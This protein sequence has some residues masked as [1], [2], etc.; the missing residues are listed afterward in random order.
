MSNYPLSFYAKL[1]RLHLR[2]NGLRWT[3]LFSI[4]HFI[5]E[6]LRLVEK[7]SASLERRFSLPGSNSIEENALKWNNYRWERGENEWTSSA[8]WKQSVIDTIIL[9]NIPSDSVVLEIG[10]GFGR[11]TRKLIEISSRVMVVDV[12]KKCID[13]CRSVFGDNDNVEFHVNDGRSLAFAD[14]NSVDFIWSFDVFV[15]IEPEDID[16]YL[17]EFRRVLKPGGVAIIHHG[18]IG[19]TIFEWRSSLTLQVFTELLKKHDFSLLQQFSAWG[20]ERQYSVSAS[21]VVSVFRKD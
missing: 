17:A 13:H 19:K 21:D 18:I 6:S 9:G 11:W 2:I 15:H 3:L 1:F 7:G 12:A 10:P 5:V 20:D 4:K 16:A 14:D 8:E